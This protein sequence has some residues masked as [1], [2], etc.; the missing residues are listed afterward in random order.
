MH[1]TCAVRCMARVRDALTE[2]TDACAHNRRAR[3]IREQIL[4]ELDGL[5]MQVGCAK[6]GPHL[7]QD[8]A[9]IGAGT[10]RR[11]EPS[12]LGGA[13][14]AAGLEGWLGLAGHGAG[15]RLGAT[16]PGCPEHKFR[17]VSRR[18]ADLPTNRT[19]HLDEPALPCAADRLMQ[20]RAYDWRVSSRAIARPLPHEA[21]VI[22]ATL[23]SSVLQTSPDM[24]VCR[25]LTLSTHHSCR[26]FHR[27]LHSP[28]S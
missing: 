28:G 15:H 24:P 20:W 26:L 4:D 8:S 23:P 5:P 22:I 19:L 14:G 11:C 17:V 18:S 25:K 10:R 1:D 16:F 7:R 13:L 3:A 27:S 2:L 6:S 21:P 9:R 12:E